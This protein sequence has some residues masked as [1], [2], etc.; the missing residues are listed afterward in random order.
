RQRDQAIETGGAKERSVPRGVGAPT[1]GPPPQMRRLDPQHRR[2]QSV[3]SEIR[4]DDVMVVL[5]LHA[6]RPQQPRL[7][8][9]LIVVRRQE[10]GIAEGAKVLAGEEGKAAERA[11]AADGTRSIRRANRLRGIFYNRN[12]V[13]LPG[14][15]E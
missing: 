8:G 15:D 3:H 9:E 6:V 10:S 5:G 13:A 2:L 4:A 14:C 12:S 7:R 11:D 1:L